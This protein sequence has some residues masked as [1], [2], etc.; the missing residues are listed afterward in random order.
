MPGTA[1]TTAERPPEPVQTLR[2][3][4]VVPWRDCPVRSRPYAQG[5]G[6]IGLDQMADDEDR[7]REHGRQKARDRMIEDAVADGLYDE[8]D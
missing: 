7:E 5:P 4:F 8:E 1:L 3:R 2:L 6:D